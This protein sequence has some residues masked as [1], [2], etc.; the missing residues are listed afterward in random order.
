MHIPRCRA[1][2]PPAG[3]TKRIYI[4]KA[5]HKEKKKRIRGAAPKPRQGQAV[6]SPLRS[7]QN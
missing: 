6:F 1:Q 4:Y 7:S 2:N 5:V 3:L